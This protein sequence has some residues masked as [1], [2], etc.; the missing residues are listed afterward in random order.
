[1]AFPVA[2][3]VFAAACLWA[4]AEA[5]AQ[6]LSFIRDAEI[7]NTIRTYAAPLFQAAGLEPSDVRIYLVNDRSLNAFVAGGQRLFINTGLIMRSKHAG[8]VIGVIAHE[9][10]HIA[11][12]HLSRLHAAIANSTAQSILA[13]V[14]GAAAAIGTG[15]GDVGAAIVAG[16]QSMG[17]RSF[18]HYNRTQESAADQAALRFL[19]ATG[20]S[21]RGL[22]E[23]MELLGA[24]DLLSAD[25]QDPYLRTHPLSRERVDAV[26][27]HLS[28]SPNRDKA[29]PARI[30]ELHRRMLAKLYAFLEPVPRT[31][32]RYAE[33]DTGLAARY[34]R[35]IAYYRKPD[36][37]KALPLIDG[38]IAERPE[39][40]YFHELKG[41]MLFENGRAAEALKPYET[42]V[43]LLPRSPLLRRGL[44]QVQ[45]E[46]GDPALLEPAIRNLRAAVQRDAE[47]PFTWRQLAIAY[48]RR[49]DMGMSAVALA[50][51]ALLKG[52]A[53]QARYHAGKAGKLL[54]RGS[55]GWLQ[56]QDILQAAKKKE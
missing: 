40:P 3:S 7:E 37:G 34:A 42:A 12:G 10:G 43:R 19:D 49:G 46:L 24:Q 14:I 33:S 47:A 27:A 2:V 44:A 41:Q 45:L 23:F 32:R 35:A 13:L 5:G 53:R 31:L 11:G 39:D 26:Q 50:E 52:D 25:R 4:P 16:G 6:K 8:Q 55:I 29:Q 38:L 56:A 51:E 18:L 20:Q 21:S 36:L 17:L 22:L 1:M 54:P 48:G 28:R 30:Q 9:T 15:R